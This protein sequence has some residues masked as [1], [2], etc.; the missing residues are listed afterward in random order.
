MFLKQLL[1]LL[2]TIFRQEEQQVKERDILKY[3][4]DAEDVEKRLSIF[5]KKLAELADT[6]VLNLEDMMVGDVKLE[7]EKDKELEE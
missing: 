2:I 4:Q 6:H 5:K 7:Q 1:F 3:I